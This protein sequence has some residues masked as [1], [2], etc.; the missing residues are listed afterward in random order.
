V[1]FGMTDRSYQPVP[2]SERD[3]VVLLYTGRLSQAHG[4][5]ML[6]EAFKSLEGENLE[7]RIAGTGPMEE[8]VH[9]AA[10]E[11]SRIKMLGYLPFDQLLPHFARADIA[12]SLWRKVQEAAEN[13]FPGKLLDYMGSG[14]AVISTAVGHVERDFSEHIFIL[15]K[16]TP[17]SLKAL[18]ETA[19]EIPRETLFEFGLRCRDF[20]IQ[21]KSWPAQAK[22]LQNLIE[23][24]LGV[25]GWNQ[26][27]VSAS[28][29]FGR[30][31]ARF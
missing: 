16:E 29:D 14:A 15:K 8:A 24:T 22:L 10:E 7:L 20:A 19:L 31:G 6:L 26:E 3:K 21:T 18:L 27:S 5:D 17:E 4:V 1:P 9:Q 11:D 23:Q 28:T 2:L 25:S 12:L 30:Q 13:F